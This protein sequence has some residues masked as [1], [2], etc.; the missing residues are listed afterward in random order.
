MCSLE[1]IQEALA[2]SS[3]A[4]RIAAIVVLAALAVTVVLLLLGNGGSAYRVT[5][6]FQNSSQLVKGNEVVIG[7]V[8]AGSVDTIELGDRGQALVTMTVSDD[9]APLSRGTVA[10]IRSYSLSGI[11]NR[12]V[13]LTVPPKSAEGEEIENGGELSM[14]ETVSEVD[15]DQVFNTLDEETVG[16][17][18]Q[19]I[20][21]FEISY[22]GAEKQA[23]VGTKYA[24]P[25]LSTGRRLFQELSS[26]DVALERLIVDGSDLSDTLAARAPDIE[27]L[28]L[29]LDGTMSAIAS[30]KEALA[31]SIS[32]LPTFLR[33]SNTTFVNL[34]SALDDVDPL[35][36]ASK[37]AARELRTFLPSLRAA[38]DDAV[39][40]IRDLDTIVGQPGRDND[41]IELTRLQVPVAKAAVGSGSP[42]CDGDPEADFGDAADN[43]FSQGALGE[44]ACSSR[45]S[46][47]QVARLRAYTPELTG[48]FD[49]FGHSGVF[50]GAGAAGRVGLTLNQYGIS[51]TG[52]PEIP[53][54]GLGGTLGLSDIINP[55]DAFID[56]EQ[57][58]RCPGAL[59]RDPG[60]GG[61]VDCDPSQ[62][63]TGP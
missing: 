24:N 22:A 54:P 52:L 19:V 60:D 29:N 23:N 4:V 32:K 20:Q 1:E 21:G 36:E 30:E 49:D 57:N 53:L 14:S 18:K 41:L 44:F 8:A 31:E 3:A 28:V 47:P 61:T 63:A 56:D 39:P 42:E 43:D 51:A 46:T 9:F 5:A 6:E 11:A 16:D 55:G 2:R 50:D 58:R 59:E 35:V 34:R 10:T 40:T 26:D 17:L 37:P 12:Q 62:T 45:N 7:G 48:W 25:F 38:A 27:Q 13:Q 33:E 15:L